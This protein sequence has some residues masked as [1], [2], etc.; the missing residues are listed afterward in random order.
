MHENFDDL[1]SGQSKR[2]K[3]SEADILESKE[4]A[5]DRISKSECMFLTTSQ[6]D[7]VGMEVV[8]LAP[9]KLADAFKLLEGVDAL[10]TAIWQQYVD[11]LENEGE[12]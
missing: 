10:R 1:F 6:K 8:W 12:L 9:V 2:M 5:L 11:M 3:L 4:I 7:K